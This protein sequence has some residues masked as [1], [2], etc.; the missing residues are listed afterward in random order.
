MN[1]RASL[2]SI[3]RRDVLAFGGAA[4]AGTV[5]AACGSHGVA[6]GP[7]SEPDDADR[8]I[9]AGRLSMAEITSN[10]TAPPP[11]V[12]KT[13]EDVIQA[14]GTASNG[15]FAIEVDRKDIPN[16]HLRGVPILPSFEINGTLNFQSVDG[17]GGNVFTNS[18]LC[19][20]ADEIDPFISQLIDHDI[21]FQAE[22]Q[23]FYDFDPLV[24]FIHF[25]AYG[26]AK[27][28][29][30]GVKAA[31]NVTSTPF[32][33]TLPKNPTTPLP[34]EEI[35]DILGAAP[36]VSSNGVVN[37]SIPRANPMR[38]GK[39][40]INP[41]LNI[42]TPVSFEPLDRSGKTAAA[43]PDFGMVADEVQNVVRLMR[44]R[45]WDIG[46]LYNQETDEHPQLD[47]SH[48]FKTGDP[49]ALAHEIRDGLNLM[50]MR[51]M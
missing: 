22:H 20:K 34:A 48:Q 26:D 37:Y 24:W 36:S 10:S 31:L 42:M 12:R 13:I 51:F 32:P 39:F 7:L 5:L 1:S 38:L 43:V 30:S 8:S 28:V 29:A 17:G 46:C 3:S 23:H 35:G 14:Q 21:I 18:D 19:L 47:F 44:S 27:Q 4:A 9:A 16:V 41:Y 33:Q 11:W 40:Q 15:V 2:R 45:R 49:I 6:S 25:R 50:D